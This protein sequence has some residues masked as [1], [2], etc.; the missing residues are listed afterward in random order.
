M[1][2][3]V[4]HGC[5]GTGRCPIGR[6]SKGDEHDTVDG[7]DDH[8]EAT[9]PIEVMEDALRRT[10]L[11]PADSRLTERGRVVVP[12]ALVVLV[13]LVV[14]L[15]RAVLF[16][17]DDDAAPGATQTPSP[18]PTAAAIAP[19]PE[20]VV[21]EAFDATATVYGPGLEGNVTANGE[22]FDMQD[23]TAA[24]PTLDFGTRVRVTNPDTGDQAIVRINDRLPDASFDRIDLTVGAAA[25]VG[26]TIGDG[27]TLVNLEVLEE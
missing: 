11:L 23:A 5:E 4:E 2:L 3:A 1:I 12:V 13:V 9:G 26:V 19:T 7:M 24:H 21:V 14:L 25:A 10:G 15:L 20:P 8:D 17:G 27:P 6:V 18:T 16:G 22:S